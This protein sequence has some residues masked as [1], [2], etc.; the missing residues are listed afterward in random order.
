MLLC[1]QQLLLLLTTTIQQVD[2]KCCCAS[3][4]AQM[5][6]LTGTHET[7]MGD[8]VQ[9]LRDARTHA[10]QVGTRSPDPERLCH[11]LRLSWSDP[12]MPLATLTL[13]ACS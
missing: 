11:K 13:Y 6:E 4:Q 8:I 5:S 2:Y 3:C 1:S 10:A 9:I 7:A 12:S